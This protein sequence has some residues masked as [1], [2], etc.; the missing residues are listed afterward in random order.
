M[1]QRIRPSL[2]DLANWDEPAFP[3][4]EQGATPAV[5]V[6]RARPPA[7]QSTSSPVPC[8]VAPSPTA[9][10]TSTQSTVPPK[11]KSRFALQRETQAA[12]ASVRAE[13]FQ[14][15]LDEDGYANEEEEQDQPWRP[16]NKPSLVKTIVEKPLSRAKPPRP[17]TAPGPSRPSPLAGRPTGFPASSRGLFPRRPAQ[18]QPPSL[19]ASSAITPQSLTDADYDDE[20]EQERDADRT[21][22]EG[23]L[24]SVSKENE[25]V[26][27]GMSEQEILEE[28]R[29]I[30][31]ELGLSD[32]VLKMLA[33]RGTKKGGSAMPP[34]GQEDKMDERAGPTPR[35][36]PLPAGASAPAAKPP[37]PATLN[38]EA[39]EEGSPEYIRRHFFPNE[40]H[41][42]ALDWMRSAPSAPPADVTTSLQ[43]LQ[44]HTFDLQGAALSDSAA[45][46]PS[47]PPQAAGEHHVS[48]ATSFTIPN[49]LAL[50]GSSVPSQRSVAFTVLHRILV[51]PSDHAASIGEKEWT[52]F[53]L[54]LAQKAGW[55]LRD[56]NLGVIG[57]SI[58][59]LQD[60]LTSEVAKPVQ[61][62]GA[63]SRL[64]NAEEPAIILSHFLGTTPLPHLAFQLSYNVLPRSSLLQVLS[65]LTSI[66][67]LSRSSSSASSSSE[68]LEAFFTTPKLLDSLVSRF[69]ATPWPSPHPSSSSSSTSVAGI[70]LPSHLALTLLTLLL[71]TSRSHA[72]L[73]VE[74]KIPEA[75]LRFLAIPP[76]ELSEPVRV[77]VGYKMLEGTLEMWIALG[78]YGLGTGL[79]TQ[80]A[81]LMLGLEERVRESLAGTGNGGNGGDEPDKERWVIKY[82]DLLAVWTTAAVDPHVT[83]HDIL[84][85]QVEGWRDLAVEVVGWALDHDGHDDGDGADGRERGEEVLAAGWGLL[86]SWLEG[87]KVNK[88]WRGQE[89]RKWIKEGEVGK[90][91]E[92]GGRGMEILERALERLASGEVRWAGLAAAALRLSEVYAEAS[93]P[94]TPQLFELDA[95]LVERA[96]RLLISGAPSTATN[97]VALLLLPRL[98]LADRLPLTVNLLPLLDAEDAVAARNQIDWLLRTA[99]SPSNMILAPLS[100]LSSTLEHPSLAHLSTL[101]PFITHAIVTS[102]GGR[103]LGP[104]YPTPRDLK[105][106]ACLAPFAPSERVL[107]PDW[108]L[109]ALNELLRSATS[110]VF[111]Q[112][113]PGTR[114]SELQL[115][116]S[117]LVVMRIVLA[118]TS[119]E[120]AKIAAPALVYGLIKV[121]MLEKDNGDMK[122][123]S[124]A[125]TELF[126]DESIRHSLSSLLSTLSISA[127]P[128]PQLLL[129]DSRPSSLTLEGISSL[130]SSAPFY[131]LYTDLVGLY[132][133]ISL[134]DPLFGLILLPPLSMSYPLDFRRL[135]WTDYSHL[136]RNLRFRVDEVIADKEGEGALASYLEPREENE[137]VLFGYL[138]ALVGE[139]VT[140]EGTPFLYFVAVHHVASALF[141]GI[142]LAER[143]E[144]QR[145]TPEKV[146]KALVNRK[147][148]GVLSMLLQYAQAR[149]GEE[150]KTPPAC[151]GA[152]DLAL[153]GARVER[154]RELVGKEMEM[155]LDELV[156]V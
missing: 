69:I 21:S 143:Q 146:V 46:E 139:K 115:V 71:S 136:L 19:S 109:A 95:E 151:F 12:E 42:P 72:K 3:E 45:F 111:E 108:P 65:I 110:P 119:T 32:A 75:P 62:A 13:R 155:R 123:S 34:R 20:H 35:N 120:Q 22:V 76:W 7:V 144:E 149:L 11:A 48:S 16:S 125:S 152:V 84:W 44:L 39:E 1:D 148:G 47:L 89:E 79:R 99:S 101:R 114:I 142:G 15:D 154:L 106:T 61:A 23:L 128:T 103:V 6:V 53:R 127:Q 26:L 96:I 60:L 153:K 51:H 85:S 59:L 124:G 8:P 5:R 82:L 30:R 86:A 98:D 87:S 118:A 63:L 14:L 38:D 58:A 129:P 130:V 112:L 81:E 140:E 126:R 94:A 91:L 50:A 36:R 145:K 113:P 121:F 68:T 17:P 131:Q 77:K 105:L 107:Q 57:A 78:R 102:S 147:A 25:D 64:P 92:A 122:G 156:C 29:Q 80:A 41:N 88:G 28:Q 52:G 117:S 135:L 132:D 4:L 56:A 43:R 70:D 10:S 67:Y 93:N 40:P 2:A 27:R 37:Q 134:S 138:E 55:A 116:Q 74:R 66:V 97:A 54:Q 9:A 49:L 18:P 141:A 83:G 24:S 150:V 90:A 137:T 133:S 33:N 104:L 73:L 100:A 31:E